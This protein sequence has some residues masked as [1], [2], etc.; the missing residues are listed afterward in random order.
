MDEAVERVYDLS[1]P[2][3]DNSD[4]AHAGGLFV[5]CLEVYGRKVKHTLQRY[6]RFSK[7]SVYLI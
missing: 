5:G 1:I 7:K 6:G 4:A 2:D 3:D